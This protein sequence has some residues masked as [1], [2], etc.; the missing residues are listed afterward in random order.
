MA[1]K[2]Q[3][4]NIFNW[5]I[6]DFY[7]RFSDNAGFI[8]ILTRWHVDDLAGRLIDHY[9]D[10]VEV[11][12]YKAIAENDEEHRKAGDALFPELKSLEFL[13]DR[14]NL[15]LSKGMNGEWS[16]LYQQ[17]PFIPGGNI[18]KGSWFRFVAVAP[19]IV[20]SYIFA[21]TAQKTK[22][23]NDYS[24][25]QFWGMGDDKKIYLLDQIRGK[26]EAPELKRRAK[27][28]W[29]SCNSSKYVT[30][31]NPLRCMYVEDKSSGTGLIQELASEAEIPIRGISRST[32][33]Y[34]RLLDILAYIE[35]GYVGILYNSSFAN[36]F[37][38]ECESF[39]A[40]DSHEH[41][42]QVDCLID[43]VKVMLASDNTIKTWEN[44]L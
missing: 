8:M 24:V 15:M 22:E 33:K 10:K 30:S 11:I 9:G 36:D 14:R 2:C 6:N 40:D 39:S 28:F 16:S 3:R 19:R 34:T 20:Y 12:K 41:D 43:A 31:D 32:D 1:S 5:F 25:F 13:E 17:E 35:S 18:I 38:E 37:I 4:D 44:I 26:F 23:R 42:D 7:T 21:D 27:M 29:S